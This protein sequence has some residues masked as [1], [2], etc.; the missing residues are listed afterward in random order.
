M[1]HNAKDIFRDLTGDG[2]PHT[3][4]AILK[5]LNDHAEGLK[6]APQSVGC[7]IDCPCPPTGEL[8]SHS[9]PGSQL[10]TGHSPRS[11]GPLSAPS[12]GRRRRG[13]VKLSCHG[14]Q[15]W[16]MGSPSS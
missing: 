6:K 16:M 15:G 5:G 3:S 10:E 2:R 1:D 7:T 9:G 13:Q 12:R 8:S 4:A 11:R 14:D